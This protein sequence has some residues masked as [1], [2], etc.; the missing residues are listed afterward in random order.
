MEL[1]TLKV[2]ILKPPATRELR[3]RRHIS[4]IRVTFF[5]FLVPTVY[6]VNCFGELRAAYLVNV[7]SVTHTKLSRALWPKNKSS[8]TKD[9]TE[10]PSDV[11]KKME[12]TR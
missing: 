12:R 9:V 7:I 4:K 11:H 6:R 8:D 2:S 10:Q 1:L 5:G 3:F